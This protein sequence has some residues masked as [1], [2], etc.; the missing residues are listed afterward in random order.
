[1]QNIMVDT[2]E[3]ISENSIVTSKYFSINEQVFEQHFPGNPVVPAAFTVEAAI[4]TARLF[5][6]M[7]TELKY[8]LIG[9]SFNKFKFKKLL[10]PGSIL[11]T[12]VKFEN[13]E[14]LFNNNAD[15]RIL[16]E[17]FN[18]NYIIFTGEIICKNIASDMIH[19]V[20]NCELYLHYLERTMPSRKKDNENEI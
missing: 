2:I 3:N 16:V 15:I 9:Y 19:N 17:G 6:W 13:V 20:E 1:M 11:K 14:D 12:C 18:D 8:S 4:Q 10:H 5:V 7:K